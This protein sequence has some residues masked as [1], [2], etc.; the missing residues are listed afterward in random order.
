MVKEPSCFDKLSM[1]VLFFALSRHSRELSGHA[2][3]LSGHL[4]PLNDR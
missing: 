2:L 3:L 1:T 4:I